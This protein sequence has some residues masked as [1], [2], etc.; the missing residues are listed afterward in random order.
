MVTAMID[1]IQARDLNGILWN[2]FRKYQEESGKAFDQE[3]ATELWEISVD[4][5]KYWKG[6]SAIAKWLIPPEGG[7]Y[8]A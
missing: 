1:Q 8:A 6:H 3:M 4:A 7:Y 2:G 5:W